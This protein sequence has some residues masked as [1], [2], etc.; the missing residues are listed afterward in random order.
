VHASL[1]ARYLER[2]SI[3]TQ[4]AIHVPRALFSAALIYICVTQFSPSKVMSAEAFASP[5]LILLGD[6]AAR[7]ACFPPH[8]QS[9][10]SSMAVETDQLYSMIDVLQRGGRWGISHTFASVLVSLMEECKLSL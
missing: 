8:L 4:P 9:G 10:K 3:S 2:V 7:D 6:G 5:E 1:V